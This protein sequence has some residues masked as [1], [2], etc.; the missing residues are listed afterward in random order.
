MY[1]TFETRVHSFDGIERYI[2]CAKEMCF[3]FSIFMYRREWWLSRSD[4]VC[5][6]RCCEFENTDRPTL[7]STLDKSHNVFVF[8]QCANSWCGKQANCLENCC[9]EYWFEKVRKHMS[10]IQPYSI[11][12]LSFKVSSEMFSGMFLKS[13]A[14]YSWYKGKG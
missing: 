2:V 5:Q 10:R 4:A 8:Y 14:A 9:I 6:S 3:N 12:V 13:S 11:I 1:S 7:F